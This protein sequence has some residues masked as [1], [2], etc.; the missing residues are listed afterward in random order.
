VALLPQQTGQ[1]IASVDCELMS[2]PKVAIIISGFAVLL[3]AVAIIVLQPTGPQTRPLL[4]FSAPFVFGHFNIPA[5]NPLTAEGV[6][7]GRRLF[8]DPLLSANN[9]VSCATCHLQQLAF[10]DGKAHSVGVSGIPLPFNSMS[11]ANTLWGPQHFFWNGR[12]QSLEEQALMPIQDPNEM[13]QDM[14]ELIDKLRADEVYVRLFGVAYGEISAKNIGR[15][16]ASFERTLISANSKYDQFLR[17][18]LKLNTQE[19]RGRKL[20]MAHPDAKASLRGGNCIDCHSQFLTSGFN[21]QFDGFTNNGL[22]AEETLEPGLEALTGL[23]ADRGKFKVPSLRNIALTA[24]YMHDGRF[25]SLEQ[26]LD[27]YNGGIKLS[28]TLSPLIFEANNQQNDS[29]LSLNLNKE[30]KQALIAFLHTLTDN[31]FINDKRFSDPFSK[32]VQHNE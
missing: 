5:D 30:E 26:V 18:E 27:H 22:E 17:G 7:L 14:N 29:T 3:L 25:S 11:L 20:F 8:Y 12:A 23:A 21:T 28:S 10:T 16:I 24:P 9:R 15:A 1:M 32:Q 4:S 31:T 6:K 2:M 19:E 13:A